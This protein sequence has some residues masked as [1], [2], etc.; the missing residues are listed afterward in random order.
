[1]GE[2][3]FAGLFGAD[4]GREAD[5]CGGAEEVGDLVEGALEGG[6]EVRLEEH[7]VVEEADVRATGA[8][9]AEV[10]GAGEG[11]R[12]GGVDDF[13][14]GVRGREPGGGVVGAAVIDDDD[15]V[16]G[17][18]EKAGE[19]GLKEICACGGTVW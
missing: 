9:D 19:L 10:D 6:E 14:L 1:V 8:G 5:L 17:L 13:D 18:G 12:G 15:L 3:G 11:E 7:V 2:D 16:G 4:A